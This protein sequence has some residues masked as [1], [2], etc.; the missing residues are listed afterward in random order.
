M[1][2]FKWIITEDLENY[3]FEGD[4][5]KEHIMIGGDFYMILNNQEWGIEPRPEE[6]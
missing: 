4:P 1:V 2:E 3:P 6:V 5:L